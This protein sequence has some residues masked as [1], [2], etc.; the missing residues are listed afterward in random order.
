MS[1]DH[2]PHSWVRSILIGFA[3]FAVWLVVSVATYQE[4]PDD[5]PAIVSQLS[6]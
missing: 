3:I 6:K 4:S 5:T 1:G 2:K